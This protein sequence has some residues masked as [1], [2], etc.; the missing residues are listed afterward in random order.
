MLLP[1]TVWFCLKLVPSKGTLG[2]L[3][4]SS[5]IPMAKRSMPPHSMHLQRT[6]FFKNLQHHWNPLKSTSPLAPWTL[7]FQQ[8]ATNSLHQGSERGTGLEIHWSFLVLLLLLQD[9]HKRALVWRW[10][11]VDELNYSPGHW[12]GIGKPNSS[13]KKLRVGTFISWLFC[14]KLVLICLLRRKPHCVQWSTILN[15]Q[16]S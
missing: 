7:L 3:E 16:S 4:I 10:N 15:T 8:R 6:A 12:E 11:P 5:P 1:E 14:I 13:E 2:L 9:S